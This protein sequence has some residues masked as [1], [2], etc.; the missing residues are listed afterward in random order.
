MKGLPWYVSG[1][2][3]AGACVVLVIAERRWRLRP[4]AEPGTRRILRNLAVGA[5][6]AMVA[7]VANAPVA[8][9]LARL[10][11]R[12]GWGVVQQFHL[13]PLVSTVIALLLMDYTYY[14]WHVALHRVPLLWRTHV[15]HH[16]DL[17]LDTSTALRFHFAEVLASIPFTCAQIAAIGLTPSLFSIWQVWFGLCVLFHHSDVN[18][19]LS[20]ERILSRFLMTPRL[21]G[22]H[23]SM[24]PE[25][26]NSNWSSGLAIWD[27]LH[28]TQR[29]NI[30]QSEIT[31]G[32]P[33]FRTPAAVTLPRVLA[34][35]FTSSP[36]FFDLPG[37][38]PPVRAFIPNAPH[39][40]AP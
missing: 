38:G 30:P 20:W 27:V 21:H 1:P 10:V 2:V 18:L 3:L 14:L 22:I 24:V 7:I 31:I 4:A 29:R 25:E 34:M 9:A 28:G 12:R 40:L 26:T 35:P 23:H 37:D 32:V 5:T 39:D 16:A 17:D 19:P 8:V 36:D 13:P 6:T 15:A 11:E 33:A